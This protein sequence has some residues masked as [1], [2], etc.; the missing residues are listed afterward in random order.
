MAVG[1]VGVLKEGAEGSLEQKKKKN[2]KG[3]CVKAFW[4]V[5]TKDTECKQ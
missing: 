5:N 1:D 2:R 3:T 4:G